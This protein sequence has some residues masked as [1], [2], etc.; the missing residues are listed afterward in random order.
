M[1]DFGIHTA[2]VEIDVLKIQEYGGISILRHLTDVDSSCI[3][4]EIEMDPKVSV[5]LE[6]SRQHC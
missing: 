5:D 4:D 6:L 1:S 3:F 2:D